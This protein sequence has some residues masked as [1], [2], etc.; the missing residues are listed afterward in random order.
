LSITCSRPTSATWAGLLVGIK[1]D[2]IASGASRL[3]S[4]PTSP[5]VIADAGRQ[6]ARA[7][8]RRSLHPLGR[9]AFTAVTR[10]N[11]GGPGNEQD[12]AARVSG[13]GTGRTARRPRVCLRGRG[14]T[15]TG[16]GVIL[17]TSTAKNVELQRGIAS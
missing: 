8:D 7:R 4:E 5:A 14:L 11:I 17:R 2:S 3:G 6:D 13:W 10:Q 1:V 12:S 15:A 16:H 9:A